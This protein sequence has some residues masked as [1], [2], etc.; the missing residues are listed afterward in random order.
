VEFRFEVARRIESGESISRPGV[1]NPAM[2][3]PELSTEQALGAQVAALERKVGQ[4]AVHLDFFRR[5]FKRVEKSSQD[6]GSAGAT[7]SR[8]SRP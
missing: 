6:S 1:P 5:A 2:P 8:R 3:K 7:A 4:Q